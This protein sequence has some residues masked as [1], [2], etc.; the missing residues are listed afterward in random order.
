MNKWDLVLENARKQAEERDTTFSEKLLA[1]EFSEYL[2]QELRHLDFAPVMFISAKEGTD[3]QQILEV[4]FDLFRQANTRVPTGELNRVLKQIMTERTPSTPT[5][6]RIKVFYVTQ[7]DLAPPTI[8][9]FVNHPDD[10]NESYKR[11]MVNRFRELLPFNEIPIRL[12]VRGRAGAPDQAEPFEPAEAKSGP[13]RRRV[14]KP[15][16]VRR[17]RQL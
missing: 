17:P 12:Y 9:M 14:P 1:K 15:R 7:T 6:R 16:Q 4:S 11:F 5:G 2:N 8:V 13:A 10:V 3:I